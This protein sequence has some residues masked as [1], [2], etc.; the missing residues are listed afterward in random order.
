MLAF[1]WRR[2]TSHQPP[3]GRGGFKSLMKEMK[4]LREARMVRISRKSEIDEVGESKK[5]WS[6]RK[7]SCG[8]SAETQLEIDNYRSSDIDLIG[9]SGTTRTLSCHRA[10]HMLN[11]VKHSP[12]QKTWAALRELRR[13]DSNQP[14]HSSTL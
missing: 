6:C 11:D 7:V 1:V 9:N 14:V 8:D 4:D 12:S 2:S 10:T 3:V 13:E 5:L